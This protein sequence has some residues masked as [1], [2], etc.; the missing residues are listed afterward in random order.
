MSKKCRF[1]YIIIYKTKIYKKR[2]LI[3]FNTMTSGGS[4]LVLCKNYRVNAGGSTLVPCKNYRV[5]AGGSTL[6]PCKNYRVSAGGC[7]VVYVFLK[8]YFS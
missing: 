1:V 7:I 4:T 6:V 5:N 3:T 8:L 2:T